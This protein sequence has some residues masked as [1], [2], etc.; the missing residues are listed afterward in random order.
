VDPFTNE[1]RFAGAPGSAGGTGDGASPE[2]L[3]DAG[4]GSGDGPG[5]DVGPGTGV[6][7]AGG[8]GGGGGAGGG[9]VGAAGANCDTVIVWPPTLTM[10]VRACPLLAATNIVTLP[11]PM[12]LAGEE[13]V[14]QVL[15]VCATHAQPDP[16]VT[17]IVVAVPVAENDDCAADTA[18]Q[19]TRA[20]HM[21]A[22]GAPFARSDQKYSVCVSPL[23][24]G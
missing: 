8:G 1:R 9:G 7:G 14:I 19:R 13:N 5:D 20:R 2:G 17:V 10:P 18:S 11:E 6:G 24:A 16:F 21:L 22:V 23:T 15:V 3:G 4:A 12:P